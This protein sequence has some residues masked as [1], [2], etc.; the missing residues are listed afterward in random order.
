MAVA[1]LM[2]IFDCVTFH[3]EADHL[4]ARVEMLDGLVECHLV[5]EGTH[6]HQGEPRKAFPGSAAFAGHPEVSFGIADLSGHDDPWGRERA[7]RDFIAHW[8][9]HLA[10]PDDLLL[11][12]DVDEHI[13]PDIIDA[14]IQATEAGPVSLGMRMLYYGLDWEDARPDGIPRW[15]HPRALR[16]RDLPS[17]LSALREAPQQRVLYGAGWHVSYTGGPDRRLRK[18]SEFAHTECNDDVGRQRV[19]N[20]HI[21][22]TGPNGEQLEAVTDRAGIPEPLVRRFG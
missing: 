5:V 17:S 6:T 11:V 2:R 8:V 9:S 4:A 7:Q 19:A 20:G 22:G 21:T 3:D 13:N 16:V 1:G 15:Q 18:L 14:A 12:C 10:D